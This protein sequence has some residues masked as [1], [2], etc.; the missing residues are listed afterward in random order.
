[1]THPATQ[2]K[3]SG[4][5]LSR[6]VPWNLMKKAAALGLPALTVY[7][8]LWVL[9]SATRRREIKLRR[10]FFDN[11]GLAPSSIHRGLKHL[12]GQGLINEVVREPGRT[13]I[14]ELVTDQAEVYAKF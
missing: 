9:Y 12:I 6:K 7:L 13:P 8:G 1:M 14:V 5:Y 4:Y 11:T 2:S 3:I 10:D